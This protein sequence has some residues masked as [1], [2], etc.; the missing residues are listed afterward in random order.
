MEKNMVTCKN[1][2][3]N[4]NDNYFPEISELIGKNTQ[5]KKSLEDTNVFF[6][7]ETQSREIG[8]P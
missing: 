6:M 3:K 2:E 4:F 8:K 7:T 1:C 5:P